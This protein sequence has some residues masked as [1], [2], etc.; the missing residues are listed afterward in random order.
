ML[1][2]CW[3]KTH[4]EYPLGVQKRLLGYCHIPRETDCTPPPSPWYTRNTIRISPTCANSYICY[5][6][7]V[8]IKWTRN[9]K[10]NVVFHINFRHNFQLMDATWLFSCVLHNFAHRFD[11]LASVEL[12]SLARCMQCM[13]QACM[14]SSEWPQFNR[15][16]YEINR[17]EMN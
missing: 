6:L 17:N 5:V 9:Y 13:S 11:L 8:W 12:F 4:F 16:R 14:L 3:R 15:G 10:F 2:F 7:I 1:V